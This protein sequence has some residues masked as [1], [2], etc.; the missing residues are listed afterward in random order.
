MFLASTSVKSNTTADSLKIIKEEIENYYNKFDNDDLKFTK[1]SI[2]RSDSINFEKLSSFL[3]MI[4]SIGKYNLDLDYVNKRQ[5][6]I[7]N[8]SKE[9][10][11]NLANN[12]KNQNIVYIVV[13]DAKTQLDE[14]KKL[15]LF[16]VNLVDYNGSIIK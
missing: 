6:I 14:I 8:I 1:E 10:I 9:E 15:G 16:N 5:D 7:K 13:G 4:Q 2:L 11:V 3:G 12:L